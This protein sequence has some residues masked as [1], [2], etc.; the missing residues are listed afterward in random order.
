MKVLIACGGTGGHIFPA[1]RLAEELQL[2][3]KF[4]DII[5]VV[6]S[7]TLEKRIIPKEYKII[8]LDASPIKLVSFSEFIISIFKLFKTLIKSL[9]ILLRFRPNIIVGFGGYASFF[10][11]LF[12]WFLKIKTIIHEENVLMGRANRILALFVNSISLGFIQTR[13]IF[14]LYKDK[15][16]ITGNPL[17]KDLK[18][19]DRKE[20]LGYFDFP[21]DCFTILVMGG[22]QG[23]YRINMEFLKAIH[24]LKDKFIFQ[25]IHLSGERDYEFLKK[26]YNNMNI[27][28]VLFKFLDKI[29][30]ALSIA[31]LA[32]CRAGAMTISELIFFG[33][34]A[35][36]IPYPYAYQHQSYNAKILE[37][38]GC[39][40][41]IEEEELNFKR[42]AESVLELVENPSRLKDMRYNYNRLNKTTSIALWDIVLSSN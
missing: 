38:N 32:V 35:I 9:I 17:R 25:I 41:L 7:S 1:L 11:V 29:H 33:L 20:A 6:G 12:G 13:E 39:A 28:V 24:L 21:S 40:L 23:S 27:K 5:L 30:Y 42:L 3:N 16:V 10:L 26:Q 37:S 4:I 8:R 18:I 19:I 14:S 22:S 36:I 15:M 34:P 2:R 31:D